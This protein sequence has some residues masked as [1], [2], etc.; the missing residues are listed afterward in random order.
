MKKL[1]FKE[2]KLLVTKVASNFCERK[3]DHLSILR[4]DV[5]SNDDINCNRRDLAINQD[6]VKICS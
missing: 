4:E 6:K 5:Y 1:F 2:V 3:Q